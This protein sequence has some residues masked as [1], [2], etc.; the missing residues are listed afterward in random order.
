M[1]KLD[2]DIHGLAHISELSDTPVT[3]VNQLRDL[4]TVGQTYRFEIVSIEPAEHRLGL[5]REGVKGKPRRKPAP[6]D[7]PPAD[8]PLAEGDAKPNDEQEKKAA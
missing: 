1:V 4:F 7:A 5:K 2:D 8:A 6:A 3:D